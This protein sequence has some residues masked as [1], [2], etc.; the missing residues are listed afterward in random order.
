MVDLELLSRVGLSQY[1]R[2][3]LIGILSAGVTDASRLCTDGDIPNSKVYL[4]TE[5]LER[6]GLI[7]IQRSRPK[8]F[9]ALSSETVIARLSELARQNA[10]DFSTRVRDDLTRLL[11]D[12]MEGIK[13][14]PGLADVVLG[15]NLHVKRHLALLAAAQKEI[16]SYME[17]PDLRVIRK[18]TRADFNVLRRVRKSLDSSG[19]SHR[20]VFGFNHRDAPALLAFLQDFRQELKLATG[21]RYSGVLGHPFHV[22]D[23]KQVILSLD[24]PL[25]SDRRIASFMLEDAEIAG[26]LLDGFEVLW[27]KAMKSLTE[28]QVHPAA[29]K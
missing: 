27:D 21:V 9:A 8:L 20:I 11:E 2:L 14:R 26:R 22:I 1:E 18:A 16:V 5:K 19:A 3:T 12:H 24:H 23:G 29:R 25:V 13:P 7:S 4:A 6:L 17:E 28:V 10:D 15:G